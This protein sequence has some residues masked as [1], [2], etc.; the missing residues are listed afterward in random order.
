MKLIHQLF[1][2]L[3]GWMHIK[4]HGHLDAAM[5]QYFTQA[6]N[7]EPH[8]NAPCGKCMAQHMEVKIFDAAFL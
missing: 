5:P 1:F 3:Y 7:V 2:L 4:R 6:L 8:G